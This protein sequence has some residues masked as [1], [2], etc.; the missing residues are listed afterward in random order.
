MCWNASISLNTFLFSTFAVILAFGNNVIGIA[1]ALFYAS[2]VSMQFIEFLIWSKTFSNRHLSMV[3]LLLILSQ[4]I[5]SLLRIKE[6]NLLIPLVASYSLF[7]IYILFQWNKI[8]FR[9]IKS[10]NGHLSWK[11]LDLPFIGVL[12]WMFFFFIPFIINKEYLFF[13]V[14]LLVVIICYI[15]FYETQTWGSLWCWISNAAAIFLLYKV[16]AKDIC[17]KFV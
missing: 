9:S 8:D 5:F 15:L 17:I 1:S 2:F 13:I 14:I 10:S 7:V 16:F 4:P 12:V 3:A 6:K 11:W